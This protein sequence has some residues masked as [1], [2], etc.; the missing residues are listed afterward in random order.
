MTREM[1]QGLCRSYE[2]IAKTERLI[3]TSSEQIQES[4][5]LLLVSRSALIFPYQ[6]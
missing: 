4:E 5:I 6:N 3:V 1:T 2:L